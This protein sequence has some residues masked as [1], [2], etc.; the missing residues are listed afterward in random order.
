MEEKEEEDE[1]EEESGD[2]LEVGSASSS[3]SD[4]VSMWKEGLLLEAIR[5]GK[6]RELLADIDKG[7]ESEEEVEV[8]GLD[9]DWEAN[10]VV[11]EGVWIE[12]FSFCILKNQTK[13]VNER[14]KKKKKNNKKRVFRNVVEFVSVLV[15]ILILKRTGGLNWI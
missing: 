9:S 14:K 5:W 3:S 2:L 10:S 1:V 6:S 11:I 13:R 8:E 12:E 7:A 15:W 4:E